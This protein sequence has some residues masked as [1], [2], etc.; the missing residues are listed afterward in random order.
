MVS[1]PQLSVSVGKNEQ[2]TKGQAVK[3]ASSSG[4]VKEIYVGNLDYY[5]APEELEALFSQIG[6][7]VSMS[8]PL[9]FVTH[10][11]RGLGFVKMSTQS[12]AEDAVERLDG[13]TFRG[14]ILHLNWSRGLSH[15]E[16]PI[17]RW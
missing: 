13:Q 1:S 9:D 8:I 16:R 15:M 4:F 17:R 14:R 7:I 10:H 12:E 3:T 11:N 6:T 2:Q 5:T